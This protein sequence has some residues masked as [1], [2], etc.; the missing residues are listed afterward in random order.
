M[1]TPY[2]KLLFLIIVLALN[3]HSAEVQQDYS[4]IYLASRP[5]V[6]PDGKEFVFEW[7]DSIWIASTKGGKARPL[8]MTPSKD[9]WPVFS[10]DG[11]N[12]A[13][14]SDRDGGWKIFTHNLKSGKTEQITDHSESSTPFCWSKDG[15]AIIS[16]VYRDDPGG[17]RYTR[18]ASITRAN[19]KTESVLFDTYGD[20]PSL[21]PDGKRLLFTREGYPIY[22][23]GV[24]SSKACQIWM[25]NL[26]SGKFTEIIKRLTDAR[27]PLWTP[28]GEGFYYVG[29]QNGA[30]NIWHHDL[31]SGKERQVTF[32]KDDSI[33][34]PSLS[35]DGKTMAFRQL[36]DFYAINPEKNSKNPRKIVL[37]PSQKPLRP[38]SRRRYYNSCWNND[39]DGDVS[40]CD[41]GMQI[42][43]TSG[44]DLFVM[45]TKLHEPVCV[46]SD[47]LTHE[48]S[49]AFSKDGKTLYYISDHGDGS[50]LWK[51]ECTET[52]K[53]WWE[54]AKF[55]KTVL[56]ND[57]K[58]RSGL[59]VSPDN[60]KLCW[61]EPVGNLVIADT[62]ANTISQHRANSGIGRV[63]WSPDSRWLVAGMTDNY[64]NS[65]IW[66]LSTDGK[67]QPYNISR[68]FSWD[69]YPTWSNDGKIIA[70]IGSRENGQQKI[71]YVYLT[72]E[73][74]KFA[75]RG[76]S[77]EEARNAI[78]TE[79]GQK[80]NGDKSAK[81]KEKKTEINFEE[82]HTRVRTI[83]LKDAKGI[84]TPF[85]SEKNPSTLAF[86]A[87]ING[88]KGTWKLSIPG[89]LKP[90]KMTDKTGKSPEWIAKG[91]KLL[92]ISDRKP[93]LFTKII[94]VNVYQNTDIAEYQELGFL[95]AWGRLRD[96]FYDPNYHGADWDAIK[97]KYRLAARNAP[98]YS[99]FARVLHLLNGELRASHLG[100]TSTDTSKKEWDIE[101]KNHSWK[102]E[103]GHLGLLYDTDYKGKGWRVKSVIPD[104]PAD[105]AVE[106][107]KPNDIILSINRKAVEP[108]IDPATVLNR[109][110]GVPVSI[111]VQSGT[112][113][114]RTVTIKPV[115]YKKVHELRN[116]EMYLNRRA[117]VKKCSENK[118][119]YLHIAKMQ[120]KNYYK[121]EQEIF[122][123]G[124]GKEGMVIDVRDNLGGFTADYIINVL[125]GMNHSVSVMRDAKPA[126]LSGYWGRPVFD[127]PIV[128]LCNQNTGSNGEIFT[129]AIKTLKR[130]KV[131]GVTTSGAVIATS[132]HSLLD[133]GK[134]RLP[135]RGWFLPDGRNM[136]FHGAQP[137]VEIW[138]TPEDEMKGFDRQ[139]EK[140]VEVLKDEVEEYRK[141]H[142][143]FKPQYERSN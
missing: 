55:N 1:K 82:L 18:I 29:G 142:P 110:A 87:T 34:H 119:G 45:D 9:A 127:K 56:L 32:F 59:Q 48:R 98:S 23:K 74:E 69:G 22:R 8:E 111:E 137:D 75:Q 101:V 46:H 10:R 129:H 77:M 80:N 92:W 130:G 30:M 134:L 42:A 97:E 143:A 73:D 136:D 72:P 54:N 135:H 5:S 132:D 21:S 88:V 31:K 67:T 78:L 104:G 12:V 122:A 90:A 28:D 41:F 84:S 7:C 62:D 102:E 2:R 126:Y 86:A 93:A 140:A 91:D 138:N 6:A 124:F 99:V 37:H 24:H 25:Y 117:I 36:F 13:F 128:V 40:F 27:T 116:N 19:K 89:N 141:K 65:D 66:I 44:G 49:C 11:K 108:G 94:P 131:V 16:T 109:H 79:R 61:V 47:S 15:N 58:A 68:H 120:W 43:F 83:D 33:I 100:F 57:K 51:A 63:A 95:T 85:F 105:K 106:K 112:N 64:G 96:W 125:C 52:N 70:Y 133:L 14:Q 20:E 123:E 71:F 26:E 50:A 103:T 114:I 38:E 118:F 4:R 3:L 107:I 115:S 53:F 76:K 17:Y 139:L 113:A 60:K 81:D 121:F 35:L 39:E